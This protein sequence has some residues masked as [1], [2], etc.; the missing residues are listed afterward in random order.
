MEDGH[1][2]VDPLMRGSDR[3]GEDCWGL[4]AVFD[5]HGG[6]DET[7]YCEAKMH[8][9]VLAELRHLVPG[10]DVKDALISSFKK[11][12]GQLAMTGAWKSGCTATVAL[13][14]RQAGTRPK[15]YVANVGDSRAVVVG[16]NGAK[17]VS[18]D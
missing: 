2:V 4:Y 10:R 1:K 12:D 18:T 14:H 13:I 9:V 15:L 11:I 3:G 8:D 6:C 7:K 16:A 17:R 5:G